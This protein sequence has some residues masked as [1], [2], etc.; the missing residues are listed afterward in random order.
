VLELRRH[1]Q[2]LAGSDFVL[3]DADAQDALAFDHVIHLVGRRL[4]PPRFALARL[5]ADQVADQAR[6]VDQAEAARPLAREPARTCDFD[7]V[8]AVLRSVRAGCPCL[9]R[10]QVAAAS[11]VAC[12]RASDSRSVSISPLSAAIFATR[13]AFDIAL[14]SARP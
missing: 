9:S 3:V 13:T 5:Q 2:R 6:A 1:D 4:L 12:G 10:P 14:A 8:H 11:A 7:D